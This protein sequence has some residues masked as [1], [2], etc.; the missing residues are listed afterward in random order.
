MV[1]RNLYT[2]A[3]R[4]ASETR[5]RLGASLNEPLNIYDV[6]STME[7]DV[8]FVDIN[9]EGLYVNNGN[10]PQILISSQRPYP[11]RVFTCGHELGHHLFNHGLKIDIL[12]ESDEN[13]LYKS[14]DEILVDT[15]SASLLMP[16]GGIQSE[17][18]KR[19]LSFNTATPIDFYLVSS[20]FGVGYQTLVT[21][22]K[23]N[24]LITE[25]KSV[26]LLKHTPSKIFKSYFGDVQKKSYFKIVDGKTSTKPVDLEISNYLILPPEFTVDNDFLEK[27]K[28]TQEGY[29]YVATRTGISSA[30]S[31]INEKSFFIR[32]QPQN[33][34]GFA[35]YRHL[36]N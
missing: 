34:N 9:M 16:I 5:I 27:K 15:F 2:S 19:N 28:E 10:S 4:K 29:V 8:R 26:E 7:I 30:Y 11:R 31:D 36:D 3:I 14:S 13:S 6:C 23:I 20:I 24:R 17:F 35:E 1:S 21:H 32:I 22:C 33:Y 12:S 25:L 18:V